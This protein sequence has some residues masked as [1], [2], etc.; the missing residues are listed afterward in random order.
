MD[1]VDYY[2]MVTNFIMSS[3]TSGGTQ[4]QTSWIH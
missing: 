4:G 2:F 1:E 3:E